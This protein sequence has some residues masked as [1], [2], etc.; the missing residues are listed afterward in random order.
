M[1]SLFVPSPPLYPLHL[2]RYEEY[3]RLVADLVNY[4][5]EDHKVVVYASSLILSD[6]LLQAL[7]PELDPHVIDQSQVDGMANFDFSMLRADYAVAA[8]PAQ[9]HLPINFQR[10][11]T[12]P[13]DLLL[14]REG[15]GTAFAPVGEPYRLP[16]AAATI[17][18]RTRPVTLAEMGDLLRRIAVYHPDWPSAYQKSLAIPFAAREIVAKDSW[19]NGGVANPTTILLHPDRNL[20]SSVTIPLDPS[21]GAM[22][23]RLILHK[24]PLPK[25]CVLADGADVTVLADDRPVWQGTVTAGDRF[26]IDLPKAEK[27]LKLIIDKRANNL[28]DQVLAEFEIPKE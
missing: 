26:S 6:S 7:S 4:A 9:T 13:G 2:L 3:Q 25:A 28:C 5:G 24:D 8:S 12:L 11:I 10:A 19:G 1:A 22:P 23:Y 18:R 21:L 17:F 14:R 16:G 27:R 15:I 20:P